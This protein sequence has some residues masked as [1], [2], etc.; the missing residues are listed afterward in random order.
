MQDEV[1]P[2]EPRLGRSDWCLSNSGFLPRP[3]QVNGSGLRRLYSAFLGEDPRK[4]KVFLR[5]L[6]MR[7]A[8]PNA[9]FFYDYASISTLDEEILSVVA[10]PGN[11]F[12]QKHILLS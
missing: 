4:R 1:C 3:L 6:Q 12:M 11:C 2:P 9:L 7:S 10:A 8:V 5:S